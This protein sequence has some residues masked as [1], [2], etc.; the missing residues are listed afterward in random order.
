M[1]FIKKIFDGEKEESIH[2]Q[3]QKFSKGEFRNRALIR[4]KKTKDKFTIFTSA[5]FANELVKNTAEKLGNEK[6][7][8]KGAIVSTNDL[9]GELN[10]KGKKQFQGVKRYLIEAE[11]SGEEIL[12]LLKKF[13][14]A[15]FA[16]S[17]DAGE[18]KLK[19]KPKAPKSGKPG[20]KKEETPKIDFCKL[21]TTDRQ[22]GESFV[23]DTLQGT[24]KSDFKEAIINHT[25]LIEDIIIPKGEKDYAKI[26]EM[27]V[28][29]G[30]IIRQTDIDGEK[31]IKEFEFEA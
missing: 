18:T 3:F 7:L 11:M 19:I 30:K 23:F 17:F 9:T 12:K 14:R 1:N 5:E 21:I 8:V 27:A 6:T 29:K 28:R 13:P 31:I 15:F 2:L 20:S 24:S 22:I 26:R 16:I 25:F 4:V 10:F